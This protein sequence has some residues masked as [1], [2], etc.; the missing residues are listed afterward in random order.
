[1]KITYLHNDEINFVRWDNCI[2]TSFNGNIF[3]YSWYLNILCDN[4]CGLIMGDYKYVM[5]LLHNTFM[6]K[7]II[8]TQILGNKLGVYTNE[9]LTEEIVNQFFDAIP[10]DYSYVK[11][12]LNKYNKISTCNFEIK[13]QKIFEM[14]LMQSYFLISQKYSND[15]QKDIQTAK[16]NKI[17][18]VNGLSP[19]DLINLSLKK[20]SSS[21]PTLNKKSISQLRMIIAFAVRYNLGEIYGAYTAENNLCAAA[22]FI[23][24]KNKIYLLFSTEDK[25]CEL[26]RAMML[27]IDRFIENHCEKNLTLNL[28]NLVAKNT[29][30]FFHGVGATEYKLKTVKRNNLPLMYKLFLK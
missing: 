8:T 16:S 27:L 10:S 4:W 7:E 3:A 1:M 13:N 11:T 26:S 21:K 30:I 17:T 29:K 2:N 5:P 12:C 25:N 9:L 14:D 23:K 19:N 24:S 22:F 15:F 6:K 18:V 28:D 20:G